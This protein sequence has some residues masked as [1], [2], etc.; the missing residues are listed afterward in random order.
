[1]KLKWEE[2][3]LKNLLLIKHAKILNVDLNDISMV[4]TDEALMEERKNEDI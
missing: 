2:K 1:M 3:L 4:V